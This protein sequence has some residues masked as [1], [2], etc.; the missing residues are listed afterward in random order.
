VTALNLVFI[1]FHAPDDVD[2]FERAYM[3]S[4]GEIWPET[5]P[6]AHSGGM[7]DTAL[8]RYAAQELAAV[9]NW[10]RTG[11]L[12][13]SIGP[14]PAARAATWSGDDAFNPFMAAAITYLPLIY[15]P[16]T[17]AIWIGKALD[18][19]L[20]TTIF[21]ARELNGAVAIALAFGA[22]AAWPI[23]GALVLLLLFLPKTLLHLASNSPDPIYYALVIGIV[24]LVCHASRP[25]AAR[26]W[27]YLAIAVAFLVICPVRPPAAALALPVFALARR[28]RAWLGAA[29][30]AVALAISLK[31]T[32]TVLASTVTDACA[33][34]SIPIAAKIVE[35]LRSFWQVIPATVADRGGYFWISFIGELGWGAGPAG[36]TDPLPNWI[37]PVAAGMLI[38]ALGVDA[39][40][41]FSIPLELRVTFAVAAVGFTFAIF[42]ALY[43]TCSS[44]QQPI[45]RGIQG[46]YFVPVLICLVPVFSGL[47]PPRPAWRRLY[48][49]GLFGFVLA[50]FGTLLREG[51]RI[52]WMR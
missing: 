46:R 35:F 17:V 49:V 2:H 24:G 3:F 1:P 5:R 32:T 52:Y 38:L 8:Q 6:G 22:L 10:P 48:D 15:L 23:P 26:L 12:L 41:R 13:S 34:D 40:G 51:L 4:R 19:S 25:G 33:N 14:D 28:Q 36:W 37:Y 27:P 44:Y 18:L 11:P 45:V 21:W 9:Y 31:W 16:Q 7:V 50:G 47:M 20:E 42:L 30:V 29:L 43:V 39:A